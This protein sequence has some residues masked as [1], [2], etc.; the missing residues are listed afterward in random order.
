MDSFELI[1][2]YV[3]HFYDLN[4]AEA[5]LDPGVEVPPFSNTALQ[6][7]VAQPLSEPHPLL[8]WTSKVR[9][10]NVIQEFSIPNLSNLGMHTKQLCK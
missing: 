5:G 2:A 9:L 7:R 8:C 10:E 1:D 3:H 6:E 4:R